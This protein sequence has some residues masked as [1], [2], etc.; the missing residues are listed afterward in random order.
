[1]DDDRRARVV[2][3]VD[4]DTSNPLSPVVKELLKELDGWEKSDVAGVSA[5]RDRLRME[6]SGL[7][8]A[9]ESLAANHVALRAEVDVSRVRTRSFAQKA[10]DATDQM[11][12]LMSQVIALRAIVDPLRASEAQLI[13]ERDGLVQELAEMEGEEADYKAQI[14]AMSQQLDD[15]RPPRT[16][17]KVHD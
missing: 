7:V 5:E 9:H 3:L 6:L 11:D 13:I 4:S 12:A 1:M 17:R 14:H 16:D 2:A 8:I 10:S 15:L